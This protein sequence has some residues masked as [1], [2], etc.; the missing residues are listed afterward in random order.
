MSKSITSI[1][2]RAPSTQTTQTIRTHTEKRMKLN[3]AIISCF[4]FIGIVSYYGAG[5]H[6]ITPYE[7]NMKQLTNSL[8]RKKNA[9]R[10]LFPRFTSRRLS[11]ST[12]CVEKKWNPAD[13]DSEPATYLYGHQ[14]GPCF[15]GTFRDCSDQFRS[16]QPELCANVAPSDDYHSMSEIQRKCE[17]FARGDCSTDDKNLYASFPGTPEMC[18]QLAQ[19]QAQGPPMCETNQDCI[20]GAPPHYG[21]LKDSI[22]CGNGAPYGVTYKSCFQVCNMQPDGTHTVEMQNASPMANCSDFATRVGWP[23]PVVCSNFN[24]T[25]EEHVCIPAPPSYEDPSPPSYEDPSPPSYEDPSSCSTHGLSDLYSK[26]LPSGE[27]CPN[28]CQCCKADGSCGEC[29]GNYICGDS[30]DGYKTCTS[31]DVKFAGNQQAIDMCYT[32]AG[33]GFTAADGVHY[34]NS[35]GGDAPPRSTTNWD[36]C[37]AEKKLEECPIVNMTE[38]P[39]FDMGNWMEDPAWALP[40][41]NQHTALKSAVTCMCKCHDEIDEVWP[42][43]KTVCLSLTSSNGDCSG[44]ACCRAGTSYKDGKC[45]ASYEDIQNSCKDDMNNLECRPFSENSCDQ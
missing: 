16:Q 27:S 30:G 26:T 38:M 19:P 24:S 10:S 20:D 3:I 14:D 40:W 12:C 6:V 33:P 8:F 22:L 11:N 39:G 18:A 35:C 15:S 2:K 29:Y 31:C 21:L 13:V 43:G 36:K 5:A 41:L 25:F 44:E 7:M 32:G 9:D 42:I 1:S 37:F 28:G 45:V 4:I 34:D 17:H 23:W